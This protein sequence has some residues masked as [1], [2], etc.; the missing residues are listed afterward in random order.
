VL[1]ETPSLWKFR[2]GLQCECREATILHVRN[3]ARLAKPENKG[4]QR[5]Q[6]QPLD[7]A[8]LLTIKTMLKNT[9]ER[10]ITARQNLI[11]TWCSE[12]RLLSVKTMDNLIS[13]Q[14][15]GVKEQNYSKVRKQTVTDEASVPFKDGGV[16]EHQL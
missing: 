13:T 14:Q 8:L 9:Q 15:K 16:Q 2:Y 1:T 3:A 7:M 10:H 5:R 6:K 11:F 4:E 12:E